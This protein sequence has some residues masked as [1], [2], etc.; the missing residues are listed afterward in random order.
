MTNEE[1]L[2]LAKMIT[3]RK[4]SF[5]IFFAA[6]IILYICNKIFRQDEP[7]T[8][9]LVTIHKDLYI[10]V[11]AFVG[12]LLNLITMGIKKPMLIRTFSILCHTFEIISVLALS[13]WI[14]FT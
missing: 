13:Y 10:L 8:S 3:I 1:G 2:P 12:L 9:V 14:F 5:W 6:C 4:T 7:T 11:V